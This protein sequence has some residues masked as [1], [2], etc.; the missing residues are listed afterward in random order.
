MQSR[1]VLSISSFGA[2]PPTPPPLIALSI[3]LKFVKSLKPHNALYMPLRDPQWLLAPQRSA[4]CCYRPAVLIAFAFALRLILPA[5]MPLVHLQLPSEQS[6]YIY[7]PSLRYHPI[8]RW[9]HPLRS[10]SFYLLYFQP[11]NSLDFVP[12]IQRSADLL[13]PGSTVQIIIQFIIILTY[14]HIYNRNSRGVI[15]NV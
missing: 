10:L 4:V 14:Y 7:M 1:R 15:C 3:H 9:L 8:I 12:N 6:L 13:C 5:Q 11:L 2:P